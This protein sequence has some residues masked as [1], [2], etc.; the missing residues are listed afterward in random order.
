MIIRLSWYKILY[1][2]GAQGDFYR[3]R[4]FSL[5]SLVRKTSHAVNNHLPQYH[6]VFL[7]NIIINKSYKIIPCNGV[8]SGENTKKYASA[9]G[10]E[11]EPS[12]QHPCVSTARLPRHFLGHE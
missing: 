4:L 3:I 1:G 10:L 9:S 2:T 6:N 11:P 8:D 12:G 7:F 5:A